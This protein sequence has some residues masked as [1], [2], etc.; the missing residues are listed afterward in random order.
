MLCGVELHLAQ[1][2]TAPF[3]HSPLRII[4]PPPPPP[5]APTL[6]RVHTDWGNDIGPSKIGP[7]DHV[8]HRPDGMSIGGFHWEDHIPPGLPSPPFTP[9]PLCLPSLPRLLGQPPGAS[10]GDGR[11][12]LTFD[13][14]TFDV[15]IER[16]RNS[17]LGINLMFL[18]SI[19]VSGLVV[20]SL[21]EGGCMDL[22]NKRSSPPYVVQAGDWIVQV[23][24]R[25]ALEQFPQMAD[26]FARQDCLIIFT[27][28]RSLETLWK[29]QEL[30]NQVSALEV[31]ADSS[32]SDRGGCGVFAH[33]TSVAPHLPASCG[34]IATRRG[35]GLHYEGGSARGLDA[36]PPNL[37]LG[38]EA[39]HMSPLAEPPS[40]KMIPIWRRGPANA[41]AVPLASILRAVSTSPQTQCSPPQSAPQKSLPQSAAEPPPNTQTLSPRHGPAHR[42]SMPPPFLRFT[43]P[44]TQVHCPPEPG[45]PTL[46]TQPAELPSMDMDI[47]NLAGPGHPCMATAPAAFQAATACQA[48][49]RRT[50][51]R[52]GAEESLH[53]GVNSTAVLLSHLALPPAVDVS[54]LPVEPQTRLSQPRAVGSVRNPRLED[55]TFACTGNVSSDPGAFLE[56]E[57]GLVPPPLPSVSAPALGN[58]NIPKI[59]GLP[60]D[61]PLEEPPS[62]AADELLDNDTL[63]FTQVLMSTLQLNDDDLIKLLRLSVEERPWLRTPVLE[64]LFMQTQSKRNAPMSMFSC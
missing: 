36:V 49:E 46:P 1:A 60:V 16:E 9:E 15:T 63:P 13:F 50:C 19:N 22:W 6:I 24:G 11:R 30:M 48:A 4:S 55:V 29:Y 7:P 42:E 37:D 32:S 52:G 56:P 14:L 12:P 28:Q 44:L 40:P 5:S 43:S 35:P 23:N 25:T 38:P 53:D 8:P 18:S 20:Q 2:G 64:A 59:Q 51:K 39:P 62:T 45:M 58:H 47:D 21:T 61:E 57:P 17:Q 3:E 34:M 54:E 10:G 31:A 33:A 27:V 26:E 41:P